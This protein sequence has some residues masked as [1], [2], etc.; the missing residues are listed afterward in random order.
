MSLFLSLI[1]GIG[2]CLVYLSCFPEGQKPVREA[3]DPA[4]VVALRKAGMHTLT[5]R[6][7]TWVSLASA[8]ALSLLL[9]LVSQLVAL[10]VLGF[11]AERRWST[12]SGHS[13]QMRA[14]AARA[15]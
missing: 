10:G 13:C 11:I 3:A 8:V 14:S 12:A 1:L 5:P 2:V 4:L 9:L 6:T 7:F 15:R